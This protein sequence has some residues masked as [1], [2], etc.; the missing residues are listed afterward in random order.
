MIGEDQ[1][2]GNWHQFKGRIKQNWGQITEDELQEVEGHIE[3]L[4]GLIQQK[5][6]E[7]RHTIE[8][9]L[10][11]LSNECGGVLGETSAWAREYVDRAGEAVRHASD[12]IS[13]RAQEGYLGAQRLV[14]QRPA[15]SVAIAFG[16]GLIAGVIVGLVA[17]SK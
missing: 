15:E 13:Q 7:A 8:R 12:D 3:Q 14:R 16:T 9:Q 6:G 17:R 2:T 4:V 5:S 1:V 10:E 11:N